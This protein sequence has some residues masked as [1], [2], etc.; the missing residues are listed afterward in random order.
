M[1]WRPVECLGERL[2]ERLGGAIA[3]LLGCSVLSGAGRW[4]VETQWLP[5][6]VLALLTVLA[7][8]IGVFCYLALVPAP[9]AT[10]RTHTARL[11]LGS[12]VAG[13]VLGWW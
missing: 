13:A 2:G 3:L 8:A 10:L 7:T 1:S 4:L 6:E 9:L 12:G 5:A 11:Y